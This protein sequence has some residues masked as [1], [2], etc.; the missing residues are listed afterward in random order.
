MKA[1]DRAQRSKAAGTRRKAP[2]GNKG[3][4]GAAPSWY[5]PRKVA[6]I[7]AYFAGRAGGVIEILKAVKLAYLADRSHMKNYAHPL[8]HDNAVSMRHGPVHS[9]TY[10][11]IS[12]LR[13]EG[14]GWGAFLRDRKGYVI[15]TARKF[16]REGFDELSDAEI[17]TLRKTWG[18]FGRMGPWAIRDWTCRNC[19]EW[20]DPGDSSMPIPHERIFKYLGYSD[21]VMLAEEIRE[22]RGI[23]EF[24]TS[25]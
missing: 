8:F 18:R 23:D 9:I 16:S 2:G 13:D 5:N 6:Q 3:P 14:A 12:G 1:S 4:W 7:I 20:E 17:S 22:E 24:W 11:F 25:S 15:A 10:D 19:P 21:A